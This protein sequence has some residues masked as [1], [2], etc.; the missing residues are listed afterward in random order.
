MKHFCL[1]VIFAALLLPA[2]LSYV[3][4]KKSSMYWISLTT[5]LNIRPMEQILMRIPKIAEYIRPLREVIVVSKGPFF[6][7]GLKAFSKKL[8][9]KANI[10][11]HNNHKTIIAIYLISTPAL[12]G[13]FPALLS[14][15]AYYS[16]RL[17]GVSGK[18]IVQSLSRNTQ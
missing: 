2:A 18:S 5:A 17:S 9:P 8:Q 15:S 4:Y 16:I 13:F 6:I 3:C 14:L 1:S 11:K 10:G 7:Q 12:R